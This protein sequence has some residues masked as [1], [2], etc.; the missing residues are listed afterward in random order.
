MSEYSDL[1]KAAQD[2][3]MAQNAMEDEY[4]TLQRRIAE[5]KLHRARSDIYNEAAGAA[6]LNALNRLNEQ[7]NV[8]DLELQARERV[9]KLIDNG[10]ED[11]NQLYRMIKEDPILSKKYFTDRDTL[12]VIHQ[13]QSAVVSARNPYNA[14]EGKEIVDD[15][16][17]LSNFYHSAKSTLAETA[18]GL[19]YDTQKNY[20]VSKLSNLP[21]KDLRAIESKMNTQ[22]ELQSKLKTAQE[23][24]F[25]NDPQ[26]RSNALTDITYLQDAI[27]GLN[28]TEQEQNILNTY[29]KQYF[30]TKNEIADLTYKKEHL[31]GANEITQDQANRILNNT[32]RDNLY[33]Y[34][35][36]EPTIMD[37]FIHGMKDSFSNPGEELGMIFGFFAPLA[38]G[39]TPGLLLKGASVL[40][41]ASS[42]SSQLME[43]YINKHGELPDEKMLSAGIHGLL[44][45]AIDQY[46]THGLVVGKKYAR[47][48]LRGVGLTEA[49]RLAEEAAKKTAKALKGLTSGLSPKQQAFAATQV[50]AKNSEAAWKSV[51]DVLKK[52]ANSKALENVAESVADKSLLGKAASAVSLPKVYKI[53]LKQVQD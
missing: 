53:L 24:L 45:A 18:G 31:F 39:G 32:M 37:D 33:K 9:Q 38:I 25:S 52:S 23:R 35:G 4:S 46:L 15:G 34:S 14:L 20:Q 2:Q 47:G 11:P 43:E 5:E 50:I 36:I 30:D 17:F 22:R 1:I 16:G 19:L 7:N 3:V 49:D 44:T 29:G 40:A 42:V 6:E 21:L 27:K 28:L 48:M 51:E 41:E 8:G 13:I 26:T 10:I 12:D